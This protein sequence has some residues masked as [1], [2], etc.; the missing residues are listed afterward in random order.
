MKPIAFTEQTV[1]LQPNPNQMEIDDLPV[2]TLPIFTDGNQV[3][4]CW[5][6][7]FW[8]RLRVLWFG[9]IWLGVHSG[10]TQPP[11]WLAAERTMF[12][13]PETMKPVR[14]EGKERGLDGDET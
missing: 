9:K 5:G 14:S 11:V 10:H 8:E 6:L 3:I 13:K 7:T 1:V 12:G 2:G 4:S